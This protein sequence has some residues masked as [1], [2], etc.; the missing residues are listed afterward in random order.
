MRAIVYARKSKPDRRRPDSASDSVERQ[1]AQLSAEIERRGWTMAADP[2]SDDGISA[3]RHARKTREGWPQVVAMVEARQV[4][5]VCLWETSRLSRQLAEWATFRD[6]CV[7]SGVVWLVG[8]RVVDLA[9]TDER[10]TSGVVAV[11]DE[12]ESERTRRRV[13]TAIEDNAKKGRPHGRNNYGY[14]R[15]YAT[16]SGALEAVEP[17]PQQADVVRRMFAEW[18]SGKSLRSIAAGLSDDGIATATGQTEWAPRTV[19]R[20]LRNSA[21]IGRRLHRGKDIGPAGWPPLVDVETFNAAQ[22]RFN[23]PNRGEYRGRI[24][25]HWLS[26]VLRCSKCGGAHRVLKQKNGGLSYVCLTRGCHA[27]SVQKPPVENYL[28]QVILAR[29]ERARRRRRTHTAAS[30]RRAD[31]GTAQ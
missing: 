2:I 4:D 31:S 18:G 15:R 24:V 23:E 29:L 3:S 5:V 27:T 8:D 17:H 30:R 1:I 22:A 14:L 16:D 12:V 9:Q 25:A 21:Y 13:L 26:G 11:V 28:E 19:A 20:L 6:L 10:L 7:A